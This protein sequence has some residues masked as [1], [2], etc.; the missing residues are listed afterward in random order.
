MAMERQNVTLVLPILPGLAAMLPHTGHTDHAMLNERA[1]ELTALAL[2]HPASA[3]E[4]KDK[5]NDLLEEM[6][7]QLVASAFAEAQKRG[8]A[9]DLESTVKELLTTLGDESM[10]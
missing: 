7:A 4:T 9:R 8:R 1:V 5:A 6:Q 10:S 2:H 3:E